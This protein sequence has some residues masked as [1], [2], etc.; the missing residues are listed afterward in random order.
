[1]YCYV[2][3][4]GDSP[5]A[6]PHLPSLPFTQILPSPITGHG[7]LETLAGAGAV[8]LMAYGISYALPIVPLLRYP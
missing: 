1:M 7:P 6:P 5:Q 2:Y 3:I 8:A 4:A